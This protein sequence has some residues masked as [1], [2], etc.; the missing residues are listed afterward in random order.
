M[1]NFKAMA[2]SHLSE[3]FFE[4]LKCSHCSMHDFEEFVCEE[5]TKVLRDAMVFALE[6][7]DDTMFAELK[8]QGRGC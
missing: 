4:E 1:S 8:L 6:K 2:T 3:F 7:L 5:G